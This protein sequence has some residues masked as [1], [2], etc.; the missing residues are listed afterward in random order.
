MMRESAHARFATSAGSIL[1]MAPMLC[2]VA[3]LQRPACRFQHIGAVRVGHPLMR[4][5]IPR[6]SYT[7]WFGTGRIN[8][9]P[10]CGN[11]FCPPPHGRTSWTNPVCFLIF[12]QSWTIPGGFNHG[13]S[14]KHLA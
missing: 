4:R 3:L 10:Q 12:I 14:P 1:L 7:P 6:G 9:F 13:I 5:E 11:T 2:G 8:R